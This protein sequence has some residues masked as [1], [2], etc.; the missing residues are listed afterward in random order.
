MLEHD[1]DFK[2]QQDIPKIRKTIENKYLQKI[3]VDM[4]D[5]N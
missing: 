1:G 4:D 2:G 5:Q 3:S